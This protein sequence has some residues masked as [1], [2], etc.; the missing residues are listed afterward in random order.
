MQ[1]EHIKRTISGAWILMALAVAIVVN[2]SPLGALLIA[3]LGLLPPLVMLFAWNHP[4][5]TMSERIN[6][7]RR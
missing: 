4:A 1:L 2:P 7:A 6:E 3:A 5:Q